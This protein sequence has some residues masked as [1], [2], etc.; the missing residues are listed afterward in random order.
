M[1]GRLFS[2]DLIKVFAFAAL[3]YWGGYPL[4]ARAWYQVW[5]PGA[6]MYDEGTVQIHNPLNN[7]TGHTANATQSIT[8]GG[9]SFQDVCNAGETAATTPSYIRVTTPFPQ[10]ATVGNYHYV[11]GNNAYLY[12]GASATT[13]GRTVYA[14]VERALWDSAG[15]TVACNQSFPTGKPVSW[16]MSV[17]VAKPFIG[18]VN[19]NEPDIF[20]V[21]VGGG[22]DSLSHLAYTVGFRGTV[23]VPQSCEIQPGSVLEIDLGQ[24]AQKDF[25]RGGTG[26]RPS[27]F[28]NR[29]LTVKVSCAG[30]VRS[31]ALLSMRL[32]GTAASGYPQALTS[33]NPDVGVVITKSDGSTVLTPNDLNSV[34][35]LQ[36]QKGM[37]SVVI[38]SYP[39]SL[40][41]KTPATGLFTTLAY[42]RFDFT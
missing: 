36:L 25:V 21:Y 27:G 29:P 34:I 9:Y 10:E 17:Y 5:S 40:T 37:G 30:G 22:N 2:Y 1:H 24:I 6:V 31:D 39:V 42:L 26:N 14:P 32:E 38:Q 4:P 28:V 33:D 13:E 7:T 20:Q 16:T 15:S 8:S 41:G 19:I 23:V 12:F 3:F 35:P 11:K 18:T